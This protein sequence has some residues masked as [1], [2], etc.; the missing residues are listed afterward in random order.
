MEYRTLN[1]ATGELLKSFPSASDAD[2]ENA[3]EKAT[4][5]HH[6]WREANFDQRAAVLQNAATILE[7][8][9]EDLARLMA[10]EMGKPLYE[11]RAEAKKCAWVCRHYA[12]KAEQYLAPSIAE[13]DGS[14]AFVRY[15]PLGPILAIMPWNYP[16][17][18]VFRFAAPNLMAGNTGLLKHSPNTPQCGLII[19]EILR[20]AGAPE[21]VF[22]TLLISTTQAARV[23]ADHRVRGVT[24]TGSTGAGRAVGALA[25]KYLKPS[26][27]ELG[28][29]DPFI[30]LDDADVAEAAK[31][32]VASR[33]LN[34]GQSCIAAKRF[35]IHRDVYDDFLEAFNAEMS[36]RKMGDPMDEET[37]L[38]PMARDDLRDG[39][40]QQ[41]AD[42]LGVGARATV[43]G[44]RPDGPGFYYPG[45]VLTDIPIN[46]PANS[47]ELFGPV[48]SVFRVEDEE[49]VISLA[50]GTPYGLGCSLWTKDIG[51]AKELIA[52]IDTGAVFV[53]GLVKSDPRIPF[54][55]VK[56]SGY[57]RELGR[58]GI[59]EFCNQKTVWIK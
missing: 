27:L 30:V 55:G 29:S 13:T 52:K 54:G 26:V 7:D 46:A 32:G 59:L 56:D 5:A 31:T 35:L 33:C 1:P 44:Q 19:A 3:L 48:A 9:A 12:D 41:V 43:G 57:G 16:F 25:G 4:T 38:G 8:R 45:T 22:Q 42:S 53:N 28:G 2:V 6:G 47:E 40:A 11:G 20:E 18:Q 36:A 10:L 51:R 50:N 58:E 23:I 39:L 21:G 37:K 17:W 14:E 49:E 24:L 34:S 15:D